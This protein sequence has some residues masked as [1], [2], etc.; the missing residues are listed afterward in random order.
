[1]KNQTYPKHEILGGR[2]Y[3][4]KREDSPYWQA[5]AFLEGKN[6]RHSTKAENL[7][8]AITSAEEWYFGLRA[9]S[10]SGELSTAT[11]KGS[12]PTFKEV[13]AQFLKEYS[14]LSEG[15]RNPLWV[16]GHEIR[17]RVHLNPFFGDLPISK[18]DSAKI[19]EYRVHR[20]TPKKDKDPLAK[21]NRPHKE[22]KLPAHKTLHN[23]IVALRLVLKDALRKRLIP[24][25]PDLSSPLRKS[26]KVSHRAW[27]SPAEYKDLYTATRKYANQAR[28]NVKWRAELLHDYVLFLA[29]TGIRP[30]EAANLQHRDIEI[31]HDND[32]NETILTLELRGKRGIGF[33]KS[34]PNAVKPYKRLLERKKPP[35]MRMPGEPDTPQPSDPVFP[36]NF[37]KIFKRLLEREN[38]KF[39]RDGKT[40][41]AYSLRHTY[42]CLRLME[43]ADVYQLA[44]NCR[45]S[46]EMIE[47]HYAAHIK[48]MLDA[49]LIN[50][51]KS[52]KTSKKVVDDDE[53]DL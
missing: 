51:R 37:G 52:K 7:N 53:G 16:K 5:A 30:D 8:E 9:K 29:N 3:L 18:V 12:E 42:I 27:F 10:M 33:C 24:G 46:V 39:D 19:Q 31:T 47:K 15:Q 35:R 23:E 41:T 38:L 45:T 4:F 25:L 28:P 32:T 13:A 21:D 34:T 1:M 20:M 49:G 43:G 6:Y 36:G 48:T 26:G 44:K 50:V 11:R 17:L 2:A 14:V 22:K 40:R